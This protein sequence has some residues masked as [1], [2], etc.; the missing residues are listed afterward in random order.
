[1]INPSSALVDPLC[2]KNI[3]ERITFK[4]VSFR[5]FIIRFLL[6]LFFVY[7]AAKTT[8]LIDCLLMLG[9]SIKRS[10]DRFAGIQPSL[11][12]NLVQHTKYSAPRSPPPN[13]PSS[14]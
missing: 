6:L 13:A 12:Q 14:S 9:R 1:M 7:S 10:R 4:Y 2:G 5:L 8:V 11:P 3:L